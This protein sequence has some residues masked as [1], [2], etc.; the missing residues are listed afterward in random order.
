MPFINIETYFGKL[1]GEK[2]IFK[3]GKG[4]GEELMENRKVTGPCENYKIPGGFILEFEGLK[5]KIF[6]IL[7]L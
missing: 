2:Y 7:H 6:L 5:K 4:Y 1:M 3:V